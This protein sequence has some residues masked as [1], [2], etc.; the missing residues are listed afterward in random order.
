MQPSIVVVSSSMLE[1]GMKVLSVEDPDLT[2]VARIVRRIY[3][4][5]EHARRGDLDVAKESM[6]DL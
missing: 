5:M 4:A 3:E 2:D 1:A 6:A